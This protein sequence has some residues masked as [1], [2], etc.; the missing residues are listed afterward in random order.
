MVAGITGRRYFQYLKSK[1]ECNILFCDKNHKNIKEYL[2]VKVI[3]P[4]K[5]I[6]NHKNNYIVIA[7]YAKVME[8][9]EFLDSNNMHK[10]TWGNLPDNDEQYFD[11]L[12]KLSDNEIFVDIGVFDGGTTLNFLDRCNHTYK[13]IH[14]FEPNDECYQQISDNILKFDN[15]YLHKIGAWNKKEVLKFSVDSGSSHI[16]NNC[17]GITINVDAIDN[18]L[19]DGATFIKMDVEG[20]ELNALKG[21]K[22]TITK[23]KPKLAISIYHKPEDIFEILAHIKNLVPEYKFYIRHYTNSSLETILYAVI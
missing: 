19:L 7:N 21:A 18:Y 15:I 11:E 8:I 22:E 5:L 1:F 20:A 6:E 12:I 23:Y 9:Y 13:A 10:I 4:E 16:E 3:S 2:G 17:D 14:M